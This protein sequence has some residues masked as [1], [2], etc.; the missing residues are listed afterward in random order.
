MWVRDCSWVS[1][2]QIHHLEKKKKP[3]QICLLGNSL[4]IRNLFAKKNK[5]SLETEGRNLDKLQFNLLNFS[6]ILIIQRKRKFKVLI[7]TT[8]AEQVKKNLSAIFI[9]CSENTLLRTYYYSYH[10]FYNYK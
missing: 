3:L 4:H 1:L 2:T 10:F 9:L 5:Q 7:Q 6:L 8:W